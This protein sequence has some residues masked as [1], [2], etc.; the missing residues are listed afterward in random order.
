[1]SRKPVLEDVD[2]DNVDNMDMDIAEFDPSL[3]T[4]IA[5]AKPKPEVTRSQDQ[6]PPLFPHF[7]TPSSDGVQM[8]R[9]DVVHT[10][11]F[12]PEDR[13][14]LNK[15]EIVYPCYFDAQR[16]HKDGRR[17]SKDKAV[18]NPI[19]KTISDACSYL[20]LPV[21]LELDRMHPQDFGNPGRVR[22]LL[23]S[24]PEI[25]LVG[26]SK[27]NTKRGLLNA[28]AEYLKDHP[29]TLESV[30]PKSGIP[31][32]QDYSGIEPSEIPQVKG[33][34]MNTIV[35]VHSQFTLKH[36][37]TKSIYTL[38]PEQPEQKTPLAPKHPKKKV[39]RI[40]G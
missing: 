20:K 6:E 16:S 37:M 36:P 3:H 26:G 25:G 18:K 4:P 24:K 29:T 2:D 12:N 40:R 32:P 5:P 19:A 38:E 14:K 11:N 27:F 23:K 21:I 15:F 10:K 22:V 8:Q 34:H 39:M 30:G 13:T 35:P 9:D 33:F 28:I 31:L 1:M 17:V 7:P